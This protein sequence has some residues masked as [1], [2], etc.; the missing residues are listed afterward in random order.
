MQY[1]RG[2]LI[3]DREQA[4]RL[5]GNRLQLY[6]NSD[7]V[8]V[9]IPHGGVCV[10]S[11]LAES[12][13]LTLE[14]MPCRRLKHPV[15]KGRNIGSVSSGEAWVHDCQYDVPQ[16]YIYHQMAMLRH[17]IDYE[18]QLYYSNLEQVSLNGRVV[19]LV[20]DMLQSPDTMLACIRDIKKKSPQRV[21]VAVPVLGPDAAEAIQPEVDELIFL[22]MRAGLQSGNEFYLH[23][24]PVD[25]EKVSQLLARSRRM[26]QA[27]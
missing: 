17:S 4:G 21:L 23:Y 1:F 19:I 22:Q 13:D 14:V 25:D 2:T 12:L 20:D 9:G 18:N 7:A 26:L 6:K 15:D 11:A 27:G 3:Q 8:V 10:A 5:L 16:D 24:D